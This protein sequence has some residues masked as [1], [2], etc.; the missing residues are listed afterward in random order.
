[1]KKNI[2]F[3]IVCALSSVE[4][5]AQGIKTSFSEKV[6]LSYYVE[7]RLKQHTFYAGE[8]ATIHAFKKK[9]GRYYFV[10]ETDYYATSL[11]CDKIPFYATE[12]ELKK[13]PDALGN[14]S[15][16]L[17][18]KSR[19]GVEIRLNQYCKRQALSGKI[20]ETIYSPEK[21]DFVSG[22]NYKLKKNDTVYVV[23]RKSTSSNDYYALYGKKFAGIYK[24]PS[25]YKFVYG[26]GVD[27]KRL[28]STDDPD[29]QR[30]LTEKQREIEQQRAEAKVEYR[31]KA[32]NCEI[33]GIM[34]GF[35][36]DPMGDIRARYL[37][38]D[39]TMIIGY[40]KIGDEHYF[41]LYSDALVGTFKHSWEP[42]STFKN[43]DEI[44]FDLLPAYNDPE[45]VSFI[46]KKAAIVDSLN[47]IKRLES[48]KGLNEFITGH[49]GT[50]KKNSPFIISDISWSANSVGGIEVSLS[51]TNCTGQ[52]IKYI[53]FQGYFINAVGDKC[54]N[55][56]SGSTTWKARGV[57]PIG[58]CPTTAD[59]Y[60]DR[61]NNCGAR[62]SFDDLTF[63][64]RVAHTF[65]L[66]SVTVEY[67]SGRKITLSGANLNKH[68]KY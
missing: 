53:T 17:L 26:D 51:I 1:M 2:F 39:T 61:K 67:T 31:R 14:E 40:S 34:T 36:P 56:I 3:F 6:V 29:V 23:G 9:S 24:I 10:V 16:A 7:Y 58:P 47:E 37:K 25:T 30:I 19:Q 8:S 64:T 35:S 27:I 49:I 44:E 43:S 63:Y 38:G 45:V 4:V 68:V 22:T 18:R 12:K 32:L 13:L 60:Y 57:G 28:P 15:D 21:F 46:Q 11:N 20:S 65:R 54:R 42:K 55:D 33:K 59:N 41:A 50:Y 62:Y 48:L 52:T 66:S 5:C